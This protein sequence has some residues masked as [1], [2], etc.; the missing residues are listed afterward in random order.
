MAA[1]R[2]LKRLFKQVCDRFVAVTF[3]VVFLSSIIEHLKGFDSACKI[4]ENRIKGL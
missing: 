4:V 2:L 1:F 3:G